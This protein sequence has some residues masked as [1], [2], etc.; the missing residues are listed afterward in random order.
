MIQSNTLNDFLVLTHMFFNSKLE[1]LL[2]ATKGFEIKDAWE[3]LKA[4]SAVG[5]MSDT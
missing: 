5:H 4:R 1:L 2:I 3:S